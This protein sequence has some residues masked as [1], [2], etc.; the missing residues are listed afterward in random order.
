MVRQELNRIGT[1]MVESFTV[2][3]QP[4]LDPF[5]DPLFSLEIKDVPFPDYFC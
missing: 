3:K 1:I 5:G 4:P 2:V